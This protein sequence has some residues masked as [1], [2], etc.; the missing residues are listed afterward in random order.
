[1]VADYLRKNLLA[2]ME[3]RSLNEAQLAREAS[4]PQPTMHKLMS[5]ATIDPRISTLEPIARFFG[6]SIDQLVGK[7]PLDAHLVNL[8]SDLILD[9]RIPFLPWKKIDKTYVDLNNL[10][11]SN[12]EYWLTVNQSVSQNSFATQIRNCSFPAPFLDDST[13]IV[14]KNLGSMNGNYVLLQSKDNHFITIKKCLYD[15]KDAW[16]MSLIEGIQPILLNQD[17]W[18]IYGIITEVRMPL[19]LKEVN[20]ES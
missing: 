2:L 18:I 9:I 4:I 8:T 20:H 1:M 14:D 11:L 3:A 6:I 15:G 10:N 16:L 13:I 12:W 17:D 7:A 5:G 19:R